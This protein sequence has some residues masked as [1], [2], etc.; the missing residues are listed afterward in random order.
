LYIKIFLPKTMKKEIL[1]SLT[2]QPGRTHSA[3]DFETDYTGGVSKGDAEKGL[4]SAVERLGR[5]QSKLYAVDRHSVLV[6]FQAMDAA[7]K[8]GTIRHVM[9]GVDPQGVH[10]VSFKQP[11]YEDLEHGFLWRIFRNLPEKGCIGI[12]NRSH[13]EEVIVTRVH[14]ELVLHQ[15]IVGVDRPEDVSDGFW[16]TRYR[17]IND[18]ERYLTENGV[19]ILK[20]FLNVSRKEQLDRFH[21]RLDDPAA[22]WKF[23]LNDVRESSFWEQYMAAYSDMLTA[24]STPHAPWYVIPA[25]NKWFMRWA[26]AEILCSRMKDLA[27][28]YPVLEPEK[29]KELRAAVKQAHE[30]QSQ[31]KKPHQNQPHA[32]KPATK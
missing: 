26:V 12:F 22:N 25:D 11:S 31:E 18:F 13:Y 27:L 24:T 17:Q 30:N 10:A 21:E 32:K 28:D 1:K 9:R 4:E 20:F 23:S 3:A 15:R 16:Q 6:V 2:A 14:P 19:V 29:L 8:D 5:L 7:G